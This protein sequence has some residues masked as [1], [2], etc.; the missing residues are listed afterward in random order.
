VAE[1]KHSRLR[2]AVSYVST[3]FAQDSAH[4]AHEPPNMY[5]SVKQPLSLRLGEHLDVGYSTRR[6][7]YNSQQRIVY[8]V[9]HERGLPTIR[10]SLPYTRPTRP[11]RSSPSTLPG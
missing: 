5:A 11:A 8:L 4:L 10:T 3:S 6:V 1:P 2:N 9:R 7:D